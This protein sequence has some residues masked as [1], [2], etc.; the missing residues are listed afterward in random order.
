MCCTIAM[1]VKRE[2]QI[3]PLT[4]ALTCIRVLLAPTTVSITTVDPIQ[5]KK[6]FYSHAVQGADAQWKATTE[7]KHQ[8]HKS[9]TA[10][11]RMLSCLFVRFVVHH[12]TRRPVKW[13]LYHHHFAL[14]CTFQLT[15]LL[16]TVCQ[17]QQ[18]HS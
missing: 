11:D 13:S 18:C 3:T 17:R 8:Q 6:Y 4:S 1:S 7:H 16:P 12:P 9:Q 14:K 10:V 5:S 15:T 2:A